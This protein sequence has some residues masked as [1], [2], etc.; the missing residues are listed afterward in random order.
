MT[1]RRIVKKGYFCGVAVLMMCPML[2]SAEDISSAATDLCEKV[3]V[4]ATQQIAEEDLTPELRQMMEP[5]LDTM[6]DNMQAKVQ[7]VEV[8]HPLHQPAIDCMRSMESLSC[9]AM[10]S[11]DSL[12]TP[13]CETYEKMAKEYSVAP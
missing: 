3:R 5:M 12:Q 7:E 6:C 8:G 10:R 13:E 11:P 1:G 9:E 2:A 4:C